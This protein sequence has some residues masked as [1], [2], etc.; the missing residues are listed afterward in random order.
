MR[1]VQIFLAFVV[2]WEINAQ[3]GGFYIYDCDSCKCDAWYS[4]YPFT[5]DTGCLNTGGVGSWIGLEED[6]TSTTSCTVYFDEDC[7]GDWE[8]VGVWYGNLWGCT[9]TRATILSVSC[10]NH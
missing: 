1:F 2:V 8:H 6:S 5:G 3:I 10:S 9:E 7:G 4:Y